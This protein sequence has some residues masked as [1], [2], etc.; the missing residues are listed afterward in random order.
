MHTPTRRGILF[1]IVSL[2][3]CSCTQTRPT[4]LVTNLVPIAVVDPKMAS[5]VLSILDAAGIPSEVDGSAVF[6]VSVPAAKRDA[7]VAV[8]KDDSTKLK[9]W[10]QFQ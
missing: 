8:L 7:A 5:H 3:V 2:A 1:A 10:I 9:Y 6:G 4:T